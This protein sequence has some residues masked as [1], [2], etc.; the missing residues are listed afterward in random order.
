MSKGEES[1]I[2]FEGTW[3]GDVVFSP[4]FFKKNIYDKLKDK[5]LLT[6]SGFEKHSFVSN[7]L[8]KEIQLA[9]DGDF[10]LPAIVDFIESVRNTVL[11]T[12]TFSSF[13]IY[14]DNYVSLTEAE[15]LFIRGKIVG[16][17]IPRDEYQAFFPIG[18]RKNFKG[19]HFSVAH[20]SPD[21]DTVIASFHGFLDAFAAKIGTGVHYWK[22]PLGP[23][24]G[25]IEI[26][27]L[28]YKALGRGVFDAFVQSSREMSLTSMDLVSQEDIIVKKLQDRSIG[29]NHRRSKNS[30]V[31][32]DDKG[33]Y[34]ADWRAVDFDE[35]RMVINNY[36]S[37]LRDFE[38]ALYMIGLTHL[39]K[40]SDLKEHVADLLDKTL[41][42]FFSVD[43]HDNLSIERLKLFV[44]KVLGFEDGLSLSIGK[45][46]S[47]TPS[48]RLVFDELDG[49]N[50][51]S[52]LEK[53]V[54]IQDT[55]FKEY[56]TYLDT[57]EIAI[58]IKRQVLNILPVK[59]SH[60]DSYETIKEKMEG[61]SHL[62]VVHEE[63][64]NSAPLGVI[65]AKDVLGKS[66][67]TASLR[68]FSNDDE[69]D[70]APYID[71]ISCIDHHKSEIKTMSP[72]RMII[73][74]AQSS[75]SIVARI[76]LSINERYSTGGYTLKEV[77]EQIAN[78]TQ[79]F[80]TNDKMR[81]MKRLLSKKEALSQNNN[82][83]ISRDK[84]FL[85]YYHFLFAILDDTDLL[86]KVT[87][88]DVYVVC[89]L[90]NAMK[91]LMV[92]KEVEIVNFDDL[93]CDD[94]NFAKN[95]AHKLLTSHDLYS[96]YNENF[97]KKETKVEEVVKKATSTYEA[98]F[99][100]DTKIIGKYA[101]VGQFKL[102]SSNHAS[103]RK[104]KADIQ[105]HWLKRCEEAA[106]EHSH[107]SIFVFML[108]TLDSADDLFSGVINNNQTE[109]DEIWVSCIEG[110][111]DSFEK[112]KRF[113][114]NLIKSPKVYPQS[115]HVDLHGKMGDLQ[116]VV[117]RISSR[118]AV[119]QLKGKKPLAEL[120]V[121]LKS[122]KSRKSDIAPCI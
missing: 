117:S 120:H 4:H 15:A 81:L 28:F 119:C 14:L 32:T 13:E 17:Y 48:L 22:V 11:P 27:N 37:V 10:L 101:Q 18:M 31:V 112:A 38:K 24:D 104:K 118:I 79:S 64:E 43:M 88:Y 2:S 115:V 74:D 122:L 16:R 34:V 50:E 90:L 21:V 109:K 92:K 49:I 83:F 82:Y 84:E 47:S 85:D 55:N 65:H 30:V 53:L 66:L 93:A 103:F 100:Q 98:S 6:M 25:S 62:T 116:D 59:L 33:G 5:A 20:F 71:V 107:L 76:N 113:I 42:D 68:D 46:L 72:A 108:S 106:K 86:T 78:L 97:K 29:I 75:N 91:S 41:Q 80:D 3:L 52:D 35:V 39:L 45:L 87:S 8:L 111:R 26:E 69:M 102:F 114:S 99:F 12:Y 40:K 121:D 1:Y 58:A 105:K 89:D 57:L 70:K 51:E 95:A 96:L 73:S 61:F 94:P 77:D 56:F 67:A 9:K 19:S 44:E 23:P 54:A 110:N 36:V 60:L 63:K 7:L